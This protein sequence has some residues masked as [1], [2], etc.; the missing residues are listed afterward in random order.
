MSLETIIIQ[1]AIGLLEPGD[2]GQRDAQRQR[3]PDH[4]DPRQVLLAVV[5]VAVDPRDRWQ[6]AAGLVQADRLLAGAAAPR[7]FGNEH[8]SRAP[9]RR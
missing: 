8:V 6:Q 4:P 1:L 2:G 7:H 5:A 3:Q 9:C